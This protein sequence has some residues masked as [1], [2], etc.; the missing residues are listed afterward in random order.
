MIP[1]LFC[2]MVWNLTE[3]VSEIYESEVCLPNTVRLRE[4]ER[5][6]CR[7]LAISRLTVPMEYNDTSAPKCALI[8]S[9]FKHSSRKIN[10]GSLLKAASQVGISFL[11]T[12]SSDG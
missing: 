5:R 12:N 7:R 11:V 2:T 8:R 4:N 10:E 9:H 3:T 6:D 1:A